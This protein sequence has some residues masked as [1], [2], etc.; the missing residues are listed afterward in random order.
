M[1]QIIV[2]ALDFALKILGGF[3]AQPWGKGKRGIYQF[4]NFVLGAV[5]S[6]H[7]CNVSGCIIVAEFTSQQ[8]NLETVL[9]LGESGLI[10][11]DTSGNPVFNEHCFDQQPLFSQLQLRSNPPLI[12]KCDN[13]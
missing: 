3:Q 12:I 1:D 10:L 4:N 8:I 6:M 13:L 11:S 5:E 2:N 9:A 7:A